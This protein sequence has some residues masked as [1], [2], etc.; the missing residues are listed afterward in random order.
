MDSYLLQ[1]IKQQLRLEQEKDGD[2]SDN[3]LHLLLHARNELPEES[4]LSEEMGKLFD[5]IQLSA[6]GRYYLP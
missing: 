4:F 5:S 1:Y 6:D 3:T 2:I